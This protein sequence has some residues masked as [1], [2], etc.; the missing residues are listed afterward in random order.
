[1]TSTPKP[2]F[3]PGTSTD[4]RTI[5][6]WKIIVGIFVVVMVIIVVI[7]LALPSPK[8]D[9][10]YTNLHKHDGGFWTEIDVTVVNQ[11]DREVFDVSIQVYAVSHGAKYFK[12]AH[13][14]D[15]PAGGAGNGW[16]LVDV[17]YADV[18]DIGVGTVTWSWS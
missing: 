4:I 16:V 11:G 3:F 2:L 12:D 9:L 7:L 18:T 8:A 17:D 13:I 1:M 15:L 5:E 14:G 10:T 6:P